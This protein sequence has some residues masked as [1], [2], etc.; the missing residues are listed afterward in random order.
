MPT[1]GSA[2]GVW[3]R[4]HRLNQRMTQ[5]ALALRAG[6]TRGYIAAIETGRANP[7]LDVVS[8]VA[9]ALDIEV[10]WRLQ[11]SIVHADPDVRDVVHARCSAYVDRRLRHAGFET[12]REVEIV[13]ARSHGWIDLLAFEP[14]RA[15]LLIVEVK[16]RIDDLGALER[17]VAWYERSAL[18]VAWRVG[19]RPA[20]I[21]TWLAVL[22]TAEADALILANRALFDVAFPGRAPEVLRWLDGGGSVLPGR[23]LALIDPLSRRGDWLIRTR[24]DGRRSELPYGSVRDAAAR[25]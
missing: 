25:L 6:V 7:T 4:H 22:A 18:D 24:I 11:P 23:S 1:L 10:G 19:W 14:E 20:R 2:F 21:A 16:T 9:G 12:A 5:D 13:H 17:Q 15:T 3:C 8:R